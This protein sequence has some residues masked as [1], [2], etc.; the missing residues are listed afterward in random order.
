[1]VVL[2]AVFRIDRREVRAGWGDKL[3]ALMIVQVTE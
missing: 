1:M 2:A 3:E